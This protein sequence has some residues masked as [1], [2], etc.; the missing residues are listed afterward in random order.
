MGKIRIQGSNGEIRLRKSK[1]LVGLRMAHSRDL[2]TTPDYVQQELHPN[3]GGFQLVELQ[4]DGTGLEDKLD[5]VRQQEEVESGTHVYFPEG[6]NKPLVPTG[7]LYFT[8]EPGVSEQEQLL[9][10]DEFHLELV[11]RRTPEQLLARITPQSFNPIRVADLAG[12][13]CLVRQVLPDFD[14]I[15]DEYDD[16]AIPGDQLL[17]HQWYLQNNGFLPDAQ[18][19]LLRGADARVVNAWKRLGN[20]GSNQVTVAVIDNG[21]DLS[22]PDFQGKVYRPFDM[23]NNSPQLTG[24]NPQYA[25]GTPCASIAIA[26]SNGSGMV[27]VAPNARFM[28][29][30]GT[31]FNSLTTERMFNYCV[32]NGAD[33]ISCS[34]GTTDP[35]YQLDGFKQQAIARAAREG[36][37]GKGCVILF[38]VGNDSKTLVNYY[39]SHPD[40]IAVGAST[41]DD[42]F[43]TYSNQGPEVTVCAP[44]NGEW[45]LLAAR[46][47]WDPGAIDQYG[48]YRYWIDGRSRGNQYKHFGG[49]SGAT[50]LVAGVCALILS[51]NPNLSAAEVKQ[52]LIQTA[53]KI[54]RPEEYVAGHSRKYGYGRVNAERAVLEALRRRNA[55]PATNPAQPITPPVSPT[56]S[57]GTTPPSTG[58]GVQVGA[59]TSF[60]GASNQG[61]QLQTYFKQ[62]AFIKPQTLNGQTLYK[63]LIGQ[64]TDPRQA[65]A[66]QGQLQTAGFNGFVKNFA[67]L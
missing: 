9:V 16:R 53:D 60:D 46:A 34:W 54:G 28:P 67:D 44:S 62:P 33:I 26:A 55:A 22:H 37:G 15:L 4:T 57:A 58:W 49:T 59:Y 12:Q 43:A 13:S 41:S 27:G 3:L 63:L 2:F 20:L 1:R 21:F 39:A 38:A 10:L 56:S 8:F 31:S 65:T 29:I 64:F 45:P 36:R 48:E 51:A 6:S 5:Q 7:I 47:S 61:K 50:P 23:W 42:S 19:R 17:P 66:L 24:G 18:A 30:N 25:H 35:A 32:A 52:I 11:E 14:T 40:V